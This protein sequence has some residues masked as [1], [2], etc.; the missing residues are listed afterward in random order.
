[1]FHFTIRKIKY[2]LQSQR[3]LAIIC[4]YLTQRGAIMLEQ[5][6]VDLVTADLAAKGRVD[7]YY[8]IRDG[9]IVDII[10]D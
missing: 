2:H 7:A 5:Y 8:I 6:K 4:F 1:M 9:K 10:I 3:A